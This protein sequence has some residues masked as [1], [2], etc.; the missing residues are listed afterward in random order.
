ME[1]EFVKDLQLGFDRFDVLVVDLGLRIEEGVV[2]ANA[3]RSSGSGSTIAHQNFFSGDPLFE[4]L[5]FAVKSGQVVSFVETRL[6]LH[7]L[8][9]LIVKNFCSSRH[10]LPRFL[11][12]LI[13]HLGLFAAP[14][15]VYEFGGLRCGLSS[16]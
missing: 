10:K 4:L 13:T 2:R 6:S 12:I 1:S 5:H 7:P 15:P 11:H 9:V 3:I 14:L 8:Q 16:Q